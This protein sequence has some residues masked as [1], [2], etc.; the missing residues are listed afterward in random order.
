[1]SAP[2]IGGP[3][4]EAW[5]TMLHGERER[6]L[7]KAKAR[8]EADREHYEA[9]RIQALAEFLAARDDDAR[10]DMSVEMLDAGLSALREA[11]GLKDL[12]SY[13][14]YTLNPGD[15]E[16]AVCDIYMAMMAAKP[17]ETP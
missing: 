3:A 17:P 8:F 9:R 7:A 15:E 6:N 1:M 2:P 10:G 16:R 5:V 14:D 11:G 13:G 4:F 12:D